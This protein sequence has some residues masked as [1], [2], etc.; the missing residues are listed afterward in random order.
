MRLLE[1]K[2]RRTDKEAGLYYCPVERQLSFLLFFFSGLY[3][4]GFHLIKLFY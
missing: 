4:F 3:Y 1:G 2:V